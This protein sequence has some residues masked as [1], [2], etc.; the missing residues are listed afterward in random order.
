AVAAADVEQPRGPREAAQRAQDEPAP[1]AEPEVP[2]LG[3]RQR[4]PAVLG[5]GAA[6]VGQLGR[7]QQPALLGL[8]PPAAALATP[9]LRLELARAGEAA[10]HASSTAR[11]MPL[12]PKPLPL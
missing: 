2:R 4:A 11:P 1:R 3:G 12:A 8:R 10:L 9:V 7:E 6:A 5:V